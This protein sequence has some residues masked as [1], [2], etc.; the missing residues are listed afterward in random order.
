MASVHRRAHYFLFD[1]GEAE[2]V[3]R[4]GRRFAARRQSRRE[5][6]P[7]PGKGLRRRGY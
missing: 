7:G 4:G 5:G 2:V 6:G 1:G 3:T